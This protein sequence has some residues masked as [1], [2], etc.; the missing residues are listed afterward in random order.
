MESYY[1]TINVEESQS[2]LPTTFVGHWQCRG[3]GQLSK[4]NQLFRSWWVW[5]YCFQWSHIWTWYSWSGMWLQT[6]FSFFGQ[7]AMSNRQCSIWNVLN[8]W[9][10]DSRCW[11]TT[12][13]SNLI[14]VVISGK[15]QHGNIAFL[16]FAELI[17]KLSSPNKF[18]YNIYLVASCPT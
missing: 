5:Y 7:P 11:R 10:L 15:L 2:I 4:Y 3:F 12:L 8:N 14:L 13:F 9:W 1:H 6:S 18:M 16:L 17:S